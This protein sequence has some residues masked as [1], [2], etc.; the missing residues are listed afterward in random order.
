MA[1]VT[2]KI[3]PSKSWNIQI[4][5]EGGANVYSGTNPK[6]GGNITAT[7][8]PTVEGV[9]RLYTIRAINTTDNSEVIE[10]TF[11]ATCG[12]G[13]NGRQIMACSMSWA[14]GNTTA[15]MNQKDI[16]D[17]ASIA[18]FTAMGIVLRWSDGEPVSGTYDFSI[19][20][21]HK[22]YILNLG[23]RYYVIPELLRTTSDYLNFMTND[24]VAKTQDGTTTYVF[25]GNSVAPS[26]GAEAVTDKAVNFV[27]AMTTHLIN[28]INEGFC[29][30]I[31]PRFGENGEFAFAGDTSNNITDYSLASQNAFRAY[32]TNKYGTISAL[33]TALGTSFASFSA[34]NQPC[35][36]NGCA[37]PN[38][39]GVIS[40]NYSNLAKDFLRFRQGHLAKY[41]QKIVNGVKT[42]SSRAKVCFLYPATGGYQAST[43]QSSTNIKKVGQYADIIY[44][45]DG[46]NTTDHSR[47]LASVDSCYGTFGNTKLPMIE[48]DLAD[49][50]HTGSLAGGTINNPSLAYT[51]GKAFFDKGGW[52]FNFALFN[53]GT[54]IAQIKPYTLQLFNEY[55]FGGSCVTQRPNNAP[56]I[57][58]AASSAL[59]NADSVHSLYLLNDGANNALN[60]EI[61][62]DMI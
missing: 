21:A 60:I 13:V 6:V 1:Q 49:V 35:P 11:L 52:G 38:S 27:K 34:I 16:Y 50:G 51:T 12:C 28:D 47:K 22:N 30:F 15:T 48:L 61:I 10:K 19:L 36:E 57:P 46:N 9:G 44:S 7:F 14:N 31:C 53:T 5:E 42:I 54:Q 18:G 26:L 43:I 59:T 62:D 4:I 24:E 33:N 29:L 17:E 56:N 40:W 32:L 3:E 39:A 55:I 45:S 8:T 41:M 20:D 58:V 2:F 25:L 37:Y 23:M